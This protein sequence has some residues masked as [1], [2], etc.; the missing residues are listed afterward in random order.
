MFLMGF[1]GCFLSNH[2]A[3]VK[4]READVSDPRVDVVATLVEVSPRFS[5]IELNVTDK[6]PDKE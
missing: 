2:L 1:G 5:A 6:Y 3:V 4:A